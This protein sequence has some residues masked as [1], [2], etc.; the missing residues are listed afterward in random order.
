MTQL[1]KTSNSGTISQYCMSIIVVTIYI[2]IYTPI[3]STSYAARIRGVTFEQ[4]LTVHT[5][6]ATP[7]YNGTNGPIRFCRP[8]NIILYLNVFHFF[9]INNAL[10]YVIYYT[11]LCHSHLHGTLSLRT[12]RYDELLFRE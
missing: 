4:Q 10:F 11:N 2:Y 1:I 3:H 6:Y 12:C 7:V 8:T 9:F 5:S